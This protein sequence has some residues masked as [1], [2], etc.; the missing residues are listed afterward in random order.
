MLECQFLKCEKVKSV[1][2]VSKSCPNVCGPDSLRSALNLVLEN[3]L[4]ETARRK[5]EAWKIV[6]YKV[7]NRSYQ[8]NMGGDCEYLAD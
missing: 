8:M 6:N 5:L 1:K 7:Q 3:L 4:K 2:D